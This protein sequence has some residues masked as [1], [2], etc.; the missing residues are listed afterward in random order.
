MKNLENYGIL[1]LNAQEIKKT[2]GGIF[3]IDDGVIAVVALAIT[4]FSTDWDEVG[5]DLKRGWNSI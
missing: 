3:G 4:V 1:E 5:D 2:E